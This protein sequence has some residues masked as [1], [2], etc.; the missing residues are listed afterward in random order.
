MKLENIRVH[1]LES[2]TIL[3]EQLP[4]VILAFLF[5]PL[6]KEGLLSIKLHAVSSGLKAY[7]STIAERFSQLC[8]AA[9][10]GHGYLVASGIKT[11]NNMLDAGCTYEGD[12]NVL[13]QQTAR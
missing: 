12:N 9:C 7:A 3:F 6:D 10:G 11:V 2:D 5:P 13:L 1:I 8:R 4:E